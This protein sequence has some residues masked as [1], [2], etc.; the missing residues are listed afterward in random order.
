[1]H[2]LTADLLL[3]LVAL[4]ASRPGILCRRDSDC[5]RAALRPP[6]R[7]RPRAVAQ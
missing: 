3:A 7:F 4:P 2:R 5:Q 1:M 6:V